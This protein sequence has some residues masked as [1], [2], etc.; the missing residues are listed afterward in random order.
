MNSGAAHA[1]RGA[2]GADF[3]RHR[4]NRADQT[5]V[6]AVAVAVPARQDGHG[7]L[8]IVGEQELFEAVVLFARH[9][10]ADRDVHLPNSRSS[11]SSIRMTWLPACLPIN[12][13]RS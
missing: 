10:E 1:L 6:A 3:L 2:H 13:S 11:Q 12:R 5:S 7:F 9:A 8:A 4:L